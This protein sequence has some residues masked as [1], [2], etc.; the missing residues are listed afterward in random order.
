M[1]LPGELVWNAA[2]AGYGLVSEA[3]DA[4]RALAHGKPPVATVL[5]MRAAEPTVKA[6]A[7]EPMKVTMKEQAITGRQ[8]DGSP[9]LSEPMH[10]GP[11]TTLQFSVRMPISRPDM[12]AIAKYNSR[13]WLFFE[14]ADH[15]GIQRAPDGVSY[16]FSTAKLPD[17][18][19]VHLRA[20]GQEAAVDVTKF[21]H[22]PPSALGDRFKFLQRDRESHSIAVAPGSTID[23]FMPSKSSYGIHNYLR[24]VT[25]EPSAAKVEPVQ[26]RPQH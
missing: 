20:P 12:T 10:V 26:V 9:V 2:E 3:I 11:L 15:V 24:R 1:R 6:A 8:V 23:I 16:L 19:T 13:N 21:V 25:T 22:Q 5:D 4:V 18:M 7:R 14:G 17:K